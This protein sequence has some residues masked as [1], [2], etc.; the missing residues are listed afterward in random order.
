[1]CVCVCALRRARAKWYSQARA[2]HV[3]KIA[4][5]KTTSYRTSLSDEYEQL[6]GD[7][8]WPHCRCGHLCDPAVD[9]DIVREAVRHVNALRGHLHHDALVQLGSEVP[10]KLA[11]VACV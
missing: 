4:T 9:N 11:C 6:K 3:P 1:V 8:P 10:M 2:D 7:L 5:T